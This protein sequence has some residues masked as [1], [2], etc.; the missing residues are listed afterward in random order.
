MWK[1]VRKASLGLLLGATLAS[2]AAA[3]TWTAY[4]F[5]PAESLAN[6]PGLREI[7]SRVA[8]ATKGAL[9]IELQLGGQLPIKASNITQAVAD[10]V[11]QMAD[12]AYSAGNVP[13]FGLLKLPMLLQ[14]PQDFAKA[15]EIALPY[16]TAAYDKL[17]VTVLANYNWPAQIV[18]SKTPFSK[19]GDFEGKK[20]ETDS[21]QQEAFVQAFGGIGIV[22]NAADVP[23]ALQRGT[24]DLVL[25]ASSGGGKIWGDLLDYNYRIA[26]SEFPAVIIVNK[27]TFEALPAETQASLRSI[28][29]EVA[30]QITTAFQED[31][32]AMR[33]KLESSG[34]TIV[35]PTPEEIALATE[36]MKPYWEAWAK[37]QGTEAQEALAALR[38]AIGR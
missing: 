33:N 23:S 24:I 22:V 14:T 38:K 19:L 6:V 26:V 2:G 7:A 37:Q 30:Q 34:M 21:P 3:E 10:N 35:E 36:K 4:T 9:E 8:E 32:K 29:Q 16:I 18:F 31:E 27:E 5:S 1:S 12:D 15:R 11:V 20:V 28:T 17:G 25:T 13:I